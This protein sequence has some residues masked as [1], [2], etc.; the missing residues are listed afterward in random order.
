MALEMLL[1][2]MARVGSTLV[3]LMLRGLTP[4]KNELASGCP[5]GCWAKPGNTSAIDNAVAAIHHALRTIRL[6]LAPRQR[7]FSFQ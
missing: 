1:P 5:A 4:V 3:V 2:R 6:P 7:L